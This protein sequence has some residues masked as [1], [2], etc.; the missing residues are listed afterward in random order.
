MNKN[1]LG[2]AAAA[3]G[4]LFSFGPAF[5]ADLPVKALAPAPA[6]IDWSG[7]YVGVHAGYGGGMKDFELNADFAARGFLAGGQIGINK[8]IASLVF[9]LELDGSWANLKGSQVQSLG[10]PLVRFGFTVT[11]ISKI[12]GL[13]TIA[14]RAGLAADR[15]FVFAK[16]G[17]AVAHED[18]SIA[19]N[20][21]S[22]PAVPGFELDGHRKCRR[23]PHL[24]DAGLRCG[25]CAGRKLV[26]QGRIRLLSCGQPELEI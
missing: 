1:R 2:L 8:Q 11:T 14:G 25:I 9:G 15:W 12:D 7:A 17:V 10:G 4:A 6:F 26:S 3:V 22:I 19:L 20:Q 18:H 13:V 24:A 16:A 21:V 23:D 5:A